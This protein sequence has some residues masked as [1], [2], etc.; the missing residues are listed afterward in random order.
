MR[1]MV[2]RVMRGQTDPWIAAEFVADG[3]E[4]SSAPGGIEVVISK[5][6][7]PEELHY[8]NVLEILDVAC[9]VAGGGLVQDLEGLLTAIW[10]MGRDYERWHPRGN[11]R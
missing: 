11:N 8:R 3:D 9:K 4:P 5:E 1:K 10:R 7:N 6:L 2:I